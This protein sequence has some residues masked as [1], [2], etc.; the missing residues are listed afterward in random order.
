MPPVGD[1]IEIRGLR[2][3]GTI[4][5]NPEEKERAQPFEVD[6]DV[7]VDLSAAG[8]SDDLADT[9]NYGELI[10]ATEGVIATERHQLLE[11]VAHRV[12]QVLLEADGRVDAVTVSIRKL[13]PPVPVD[14]VT[15]GVTIH[16]RRQ[17]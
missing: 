15:A 11:R 14:V 16:R 8:L 1:L 13:R 12:A 4:G 6:L 17:G 5:V 3:L 2:V 10:V 7:H 9:V